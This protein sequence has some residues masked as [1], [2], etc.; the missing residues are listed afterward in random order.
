MKASPTTKWE[1]RSQELSS[2]ITEKS[3]IRMSLEEKVR[4]LESSRRS[5]E[6]EMNKHIDLYNEWITNSAKKLIAEKDEIAGLATE[7]EE[8]KRIVV[9]LYAE[10]DRLGGLTLLVE[11]KE[12]EVKGVEKNIKKLLKAQS[13]ED[14]K[15]DVQ[16]EKLVHAKDLVSKARQEEDEWLEQQDA[17]KLNIKKLN[18]I[19]SRR[20]KVLNRQEVKVKQ[21]LRKQKNGI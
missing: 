6:S 3:K 20:E 7:K 5:I 8:L 9:G 15:L 10:T 18:G 16:K 14:K 4:T 19:Y 2:E 1:V 12:K 13:G 17:I 21:I 11:E